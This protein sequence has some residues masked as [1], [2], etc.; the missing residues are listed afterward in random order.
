MALSTSSPLNV[1]G[2]RQP[3]CNLWVQSGPALLVVCGLNTEHQLYQKVLSLTGCVH[4]LLDISNTGYIIH[5]PRK[6]ERMTSSSRHAQYHSLFIS[7]FLPSSIPLA[8]TDTE[9]KYFG[10]L[11]QYSSFVSWLISWMLL[12]NEIPVHYW[13]LVFKPQRH[14]IYYESYYWLYYWLYF[15]TLH[16]CINC[17]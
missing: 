2:S 8:L 7:F 11:V 17:A 6:G 16:Q 10:C 13:L 4:R 1:H 15:S 12:Y 9:S 14:F 5:P 3:N